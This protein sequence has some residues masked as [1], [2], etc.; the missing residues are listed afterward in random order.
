MKSSGPGPGIIVPF[1]L[2]TDLL[3]QSPPDFELNVSSEN[4]LEKNIGIGF[5]LI[6]L[7]VKVIRNGI[8]KH[9]LKI[10]RILK[11][12]DFENCKCAAHFSFA[13]PQNASVVPIPNAAPLIDFGL[14][15]LA[16][17]QVD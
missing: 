8:L 15:V 6:K 12:M 14:N 7:A 2:F 13:Q 16:T 3:N 1:A 17:G 5:S 4:C 11:R 9:S 10:K